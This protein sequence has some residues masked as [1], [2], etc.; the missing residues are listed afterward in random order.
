[1][2]AT[3]L[4]TL[5]SLLATSLAL[6]QTTPQTPS[7]APEATGGFADYWWLTVVVVLIAAA[8]WYF[9]RGRGPRV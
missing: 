2:R 8:I 4:A 1:M 5:T 9:T 7:P 6:A 3:T